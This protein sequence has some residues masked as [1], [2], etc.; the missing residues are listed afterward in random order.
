MAKLVGFKASRTY[1]KP[2]VSAPSL[3]A[4]S[5]DSRKMDSGT[6]RLYLRL[7]NAAA[8]FSTR[9]CPSLEQPGSFELLALFFPLLLSLYIDLFSVTGLCRA[10][11]RIYNSQRRAFSILFLSRTSY[12]V[13]TPCKS[14]VFSQLCTDPLALISPQFGCKNSPATRTR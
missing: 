3:S 11:H 9:C 2:D 5:L 14:L 8:T 12:K 13:L 6:I 7:C 4:S 10:P 1:K